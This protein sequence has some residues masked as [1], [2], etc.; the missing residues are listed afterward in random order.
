MTFT[1]TNVTDHDT[2]NN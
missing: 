2:W 1:L